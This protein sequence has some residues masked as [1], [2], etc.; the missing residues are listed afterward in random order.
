M[1]IYK[2]PSYL[3]GARPRRRKVTVKSG[4]TW[5]AGQP[6]RL[7]D[8]G[9]VLCK[10]N[11]TSLQFLFASTQPSAT[12][13]GDKKYVD[14]LQAET[15]LKIYCTNGGSDTRA[16]ATYIG[17]NEGLAVNSCIATLSTGNDSNEI[18][19]IED[20]A[21][22][23]EPYMNDTGDLPSWVA[24]KVVASALTAEGDGL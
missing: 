21:S 19:H 16:L 8:S 13:A 20:I 15:V 3:K 4:Q 7:T 14:F 24:A 2:N 23:L 18:L 10:S 12:A 6:G 22:N 11:A 5:Q 1:T 9:A 17:S